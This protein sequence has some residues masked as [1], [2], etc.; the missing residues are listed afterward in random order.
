MFISNSSPVFHTSFR[1]LL[2]ILANLNNAIVWIVLIFPLIFISSSFLYKRLEALLWLGTSITLSF[3]FLSC[4]L[5][6]P[7]ERQNP[8][9]DNFFLLFINTRSGLL[10]RIKLSAC[11]SKSL[12]FLTSHYHCDVEHSSVLVKYNYLLGQLL[13][14]FKVIQH[15]GNVLRIYVSYL[16][17]DNLF[18]LFILNLVFWLCNFTDIKL[19]ILQTSSRYI[20]LNLPAGRIWHKVILMWG[21]MHEWKV[22]YVHR[23][24]FFVPLTFLFWDASGA[25]EW[26]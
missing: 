13:K 4:Q 11:I 3:R 22:M 19:I 17:F 21:A 2:I 10:A 9:D 24:I 15:L 7:L 6:S 20:Y 23:K 5:C 12:I 16:I 1:T 18:Q 26:T 8:Q 25:K 14:W